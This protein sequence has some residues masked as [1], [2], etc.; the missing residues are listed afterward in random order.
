MTTRTTTRKG[1]AVKDR[2][3][4]I[5]IPS[6]IDQELRKLAAANT[7]TLAAQVLHYIKQGV[8]NEKTPAL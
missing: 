8:A 6:D 3:L 7:R 4:T 1:K 2:Y 5:R